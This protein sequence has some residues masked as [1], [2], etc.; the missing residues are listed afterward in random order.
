LLFVVSIALSVLF[1][2][3]S[4]EDGETWIWMGRSRV[5]GTL[6]GGLDSV[7]GEEHGGWCLLVE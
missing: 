5:S 2:G 6:E 7:K 4:S 3:R 1:V